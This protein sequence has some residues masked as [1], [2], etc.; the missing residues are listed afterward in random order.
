MRK[1]KMERKNHRA[2]K[3][4][5][6]GANDRYYRHN[7]FIFFRIGYLRKKKRIVEKGRKKREK[8]GRKNRALDN[9][10]ER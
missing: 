5:L 10:K 2:Q 1:I 9:S 3:E 8:S 6:K 7:Q 4:V